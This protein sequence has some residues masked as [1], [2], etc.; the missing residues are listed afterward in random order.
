MTWGL[1]MNVVRKAALAVMFA[2][3]A[4]S[5]NAA[6]LFKLTTDATVVSFVLD[7]KPAPDPYSLGEYSFDVDTDLTYGSEAAKGYARFTA[8][9]DDGSYAGGVDVYSYDGQPFIFTMGPLLFEGP[10]SAPT[11]K[12]GSFSL[13]NYFDPSIPYQL[14]VTD[15]TSAG[16]VPE[17]ATWAMMISGFG[18][19]GGMMR[20]R[21]ITSIF[22]ERKRLPA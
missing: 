5:A 6:Y 2:C 13:A 15:L 14:E 12:T 18:L 1:V 21:T 3:V 11:L 17:V 10:T 9:S 16:A 19:V 22:G 7:A 4:T 8:L 20:R